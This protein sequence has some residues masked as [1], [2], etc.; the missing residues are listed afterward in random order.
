[1]LVDKSSEQAA[2]PVLHSSSDQ[3]RSQCHLRSERWMQ[4][5]QVCG[6]QS[7]CATLVHPHYYAE[8][9]KILVLGSETVC[10]CTKDSCC[11]SFP[12]RV[13]RSACNIQPLREDTKRG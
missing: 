13:Q 7:R 5:D 6:R 11:L 2:S 10:G 9:Q 1:M 4:D 3:I 12:I 8:Q